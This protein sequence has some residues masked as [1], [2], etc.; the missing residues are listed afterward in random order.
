M[1]LTGCQMAVD[2]ADGRI[3]QAEAGNETALRV[4]SDPVQEGHSYDILC[5]REARPYHT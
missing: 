3:I 2:K 5:Y 4:I 1:R